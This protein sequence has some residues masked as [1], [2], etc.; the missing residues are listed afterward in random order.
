VHTS[1]ISRASGKNQSGEFGQLENS[2]MLSSKG[3]KG[4]MDSLPEIIENFGKKD[5]RAF[6]GITKQNT[7]DK[8]TVNFAQKKNF[9]TMKTF[10]SNWSQSNM[11]DNSE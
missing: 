9:Q 1:T 7:F 10:Q 2:L 6:L 4:T 11:N 5:P 8:E 3:P